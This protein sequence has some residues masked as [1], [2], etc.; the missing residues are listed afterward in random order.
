MFDAPYFNQPPGMPFKG[1]Y[2]CVL[3]LLFKPNGWVK[4]VPPVPR[5]SA[6]TYLRSPSTWFNSNAGPCVMTVPPDVTVTRLVRH[7]AVFQL[8]VATGMSEH[9]DTIALIKLSKRCFKVF[10]FVLK[11]RFLFSDGFNADILIPN[12]ITVVLKQ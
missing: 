3:Y 6:R 10:C 4:A 9:G 12:L 5:I 8:P 1:I 2:V 11:S 7:F